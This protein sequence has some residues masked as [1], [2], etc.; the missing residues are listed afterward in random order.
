MLLGVVVP[1]CLN[2]L[3]L[4]QETHIIIVVGELRSPGYRERACLML[5]R[6]ALSTY[7]LRWNEIRV[8]V[9]LLIFLIIAKSEVVCLLVSWDALLEALGI[10]DMIIESCCLEEDQTFRAL[11]VGG[12]I[13]HRLA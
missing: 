5:I 13:N 8:K 11:H 4:I 7:V 1:H 12:C 2:L 3:L 9:G 6:I 10:H